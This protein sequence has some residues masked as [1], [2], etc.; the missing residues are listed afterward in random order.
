MGSS[1]NSSSPHDFF[2]ICV[3]F[4]ALMYSCHS[5]LWSLLLAK[6]WLWL[7][8]R[9]RS[10]HGLDSF[11]YFGDTMTLELVL[12]N[13]ENGSISCG[14]CQLDESYFAM[15]SLSTLGY[16]NRAMVIRNE[17]QP[18]SCM[19]TSYLAKFEKFKSGV[20]QK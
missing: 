17:S 5:H 10:N 8:V 16:I 20:R 18:V 6:S 12:M 11:K 19:D 2:T 15:V 1:I 7:V 9:T 4:H 14:N 13:W 3:N